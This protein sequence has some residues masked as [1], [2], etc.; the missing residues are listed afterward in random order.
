[1]KNGYDLN[2]MRKAA[3]NKRQH[4]TRIDIMV[5]FFGVICLFLAI[6]EGV[7]NF[8][9]AFGACAVFLAVRL[10]KR[11][12]MVKNDDPYSAAKYKKK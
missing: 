3:D 7:I 11:S 2:K 9:I 1:M 5:G 12:F 6:T 8:W 10:V 4:S